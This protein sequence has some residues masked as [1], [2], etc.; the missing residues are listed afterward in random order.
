MNKFLYDYFPLSY[1]RIYKGL[2]QHKG[3]ELI[4]K[5]L[6]KI[7]S[8][9]DV[10]DVLERKETDRLPRDIY[11]GLRD[12]V[13]LARNGYAHVLEPLLADRSIVLKEPIEAIVLRIE[14]SKRWDERYGQG[15]SFDLVL[16][17]PK[18][19]RVV[20]VST[21]EI[22]PQDLVRSLKPLDKITLEN[23]HLYEFFNKLHGVA[24]R[25]VMIN[26]QTDK[27]KAENLGKLNFLFRT[28]SDVKKIAKCKNLKLFTVIPDI[29][30]IPRVGFYFAVVCK[31][32]NV[33]D[34]PRPDHTGIDPSTFLLELSDS[35]GE[36]LIRLN[37][38]IF[39]QSVRKKYLEAEINQF[40]GSNSSPE[41][42][43]KHPFELQNYNYYILVL[44]HWFIG[45]SVPNVS[46]IVL[47]NT[48]INFLKY[49]VLGFMNTRKKVNFEKIKETWGKK[50]EGTIEVSE[51]LKKD[52][53]GQW[54]YYKEGFWDEEIFQLM[55]ETGFKIPPFH[56]ILKR[57]ISRK[58]LAEWKEYT[59]TFFK[60]NDF[61]RQLYLAEDPDKE[62]EKVYSELV[63]IKTE[64]V[65][66]D[67]FKIPEI[68][69]IPNVVPIRG[70]PKIKGLSPA[71]KDGDYSTDDIF[72]WDNGGKRLYARW[73]KVSLRERLGSN[74][75]TSTLAFILQA[76]GEVL[77][78]EEI[79]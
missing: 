31:I 38:S 43:L 29:N 61:V 37:A 79:L 19:S 8:G 49:H 55:L 25:K 7:L 32:K 16:A 1:S 34:V 15:E 52:P 21:T 30:G 14:S 18:W 39:V 60:I 56:E 75:I 26:D 47:L 76:R 65:G 51:N 41:A 20:I 62:F 50:F 2:L 23:Y 35:F 54:G 58:K 77:L 63:P 12:I 44:G 53:K 66:T 45:D 22:I 4:P 33:Q 64:Q 36:L 17:I 10:S 69:Q 27:E 5:F 46:F 73:L 11:I 9:E 71:L 40:F 3:K 67:S 68:K 28:T 57:A 13:F 42:N 6:E 24:N 70:W 78:P 59:M 72:D 74:E 48:D